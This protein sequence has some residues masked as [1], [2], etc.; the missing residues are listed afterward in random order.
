LSDDSAASNA[1]AHQEHDAATAMVGAERRILLHAAAEFGHHH[2]RGVLDR[3]TEV[4]IESGEPLAQALH[5]RVHYRTLGEMGIP[6]F[7]IE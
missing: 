2:Y 1:S 5:E 6:A 4:G 3:R 7:Q